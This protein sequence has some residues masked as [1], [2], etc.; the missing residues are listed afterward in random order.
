MGGINLFGGGFFFEPFNQTVMAY[1]TAV[2]GLPGA[3]GAW[4]VLLDP[5]P[6]GRWL[7]IALHTSGLNVGVYMVQLGLGP[8]GAE[9]PW[10]PAIYY[11]GG[12]LQPI[13]DGVGFWSDVRAFFDGVGTV[14][15]P[16]PPS[17]YSFP[18]SLQRGQRLSC[19]SIGVAGQAVPVQVLIWN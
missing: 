10:Q 18:I 14:N 4:T 19:R 3:P 12:V 7:Q 15:R 13:A 8:A 11:S 17:S 9:V 16:V 2:A 1:T 5:T 6:R